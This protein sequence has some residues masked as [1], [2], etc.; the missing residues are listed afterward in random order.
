[1]ESL[2]QLFDKFKD[3]FAH[4]RK[5]EE[6]G[7]W[8]LHTLLS[9]ILPFASAK[10][11]NL[12]RCINII[13]GLT[14]I[15][16]RRFY[17]FMASPKLPWGSLW[18]TLRTS[19]PDFLTDGRVIVALDDCINPKVGRKIYA[20][21]RFFDH[22]AKQNQ[23]RYPW[24]QN[25]VS[26]GLLA[27]I[28]GRWACLP[29]AFRFYH[30]VKELEQKDIRVGRKEVVFQNKLHQATNMLAEIHQDYMAPILVVAD[31]WFGNYGLWRPVRKKL[32]KDIDLLSRLRC[33][34]N[35]NDLPT[36]STQKN[37]GRPHKYGAFLGNASELAAQYRDQAQSYTVDLY[38][39]AREIVAFDRV[40]ML[41]NLK[42]SVRVVWVFRKTKWI[43]LFSTDLSL[44]VQQ[45]VEYYG[46]RW[47]IEAGF[48]ELKQEIGSSQAQCRDPHAVINHLNFCMMATSIIWIYAMQ[49]EKTPKRRH[50][51]KGRGHFAF[52]DVRRD[53]SKTIISEDF[54]GICSYKLKSTLNS[55]VSALMGMAA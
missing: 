2:L 21:H 9:I 5:G 46:A 18:K 35:I 1:M 16:A 55:I 53:L 17:T 7:A 50:A 23:S 36:P 29:L 38:G 12:L 34:I 47:K 52:S 14:L 10:S 25:I 39:R 32:G 13:F 45:I 31:S 44:S 33:N 48:K 51:V 26:T 20:C 42:G 27:K 54:R 22:A 11:S 43:A 15:T 3:D 40:V 28:K 4:S 30:P 37:K 8:F 6:R 41:K 19:I 24:A 49:L